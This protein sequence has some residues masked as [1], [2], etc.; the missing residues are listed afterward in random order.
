MLILKE[1]KRKKCQLRAFKAAQYECRKILTL[2]I[3]SGGIKTSAS[4]SS[5]NERI[6]N[7]STTHFLIP[8]WLVSLSNS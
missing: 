7:I 5:G 6:V 1:E 2:V 4:R 8:W 3:T